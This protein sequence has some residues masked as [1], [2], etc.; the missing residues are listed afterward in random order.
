MTNDCMQEN[1]AAD[2]VLIWWGRE[3]LCSELKQFGT[4]V[5]H[6]DVS[7]MNANQKVGRQKIIRV[8]REERV[9]L[10]LG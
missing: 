9:G 6:R 1:V 4:K 3:N 7:I 2:T 8:A 5:V 10:G